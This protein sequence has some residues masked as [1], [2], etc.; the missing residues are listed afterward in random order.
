MRIRAAYE[1]HIGIQTYDWLVRACHRVHSIGALD[2]EFEREY[3]YD[4]LMRVL[5]PPPAQGI[6]PFTMDLANLVLGD[7]N[8]PKAPPS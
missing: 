7:D 4:T 3:N 6:P 1:Q 5:I 2:A 8:P